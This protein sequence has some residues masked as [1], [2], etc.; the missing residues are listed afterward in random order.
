MKAQHDYMLRKIIQNKR[1]I[2]EIGGKGK[3]GEQN[4]RLRESTWMQGIS[5]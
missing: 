2:E 4:S 3:F 5:D 1:E